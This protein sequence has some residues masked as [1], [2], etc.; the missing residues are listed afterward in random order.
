MALK[1]VPVMVILHQLQPR[2]TCHHI[3]NNISPA[4]L[5]Q[6]FENWVLRRIFEYK[7]ERVTGGWRTLHCDGWQRGEIHI[8]L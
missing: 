6:V 7:R 4:G 2:S 3:Q 5:G 1:T 8:K